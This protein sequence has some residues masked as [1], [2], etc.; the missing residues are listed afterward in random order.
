MKTAKVNTELEANE[1]VI[2]KNRE[3]SSPLFQFSLKLLYLGRHNW[4]RCFRK[5]ICVNWKLDF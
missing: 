3:Q 1:S 2:P 4:G 5:K